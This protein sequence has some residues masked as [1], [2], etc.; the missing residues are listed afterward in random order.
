M[1]FQDSIKLP[2]VHWQWVTDWLI[3]KKFALKKQKQFTKNTG[4]F[5]TFHVKVEKSQKYSGSNITPNNYFTLLDFTTPGG[6]D[7]DGWQYA[8]VLILVFVL[9]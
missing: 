6:A 4:C 8:T 9:T 5:E 3:G 1:F 2:S 7:H